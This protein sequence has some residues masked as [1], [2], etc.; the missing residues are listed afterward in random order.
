MVSQG[1]S[2][3][4]KD[5]FTGEEGMTRLLVGKVRQASSGIGL[6]TGGEG[7]AETQASWEGPLG[8]GREQSSTSTKQPA[9]GRDGSAW[10]RWALFDTGP[11]PTSMPSSYGERVSLSRRAAMAA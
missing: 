2:G 4:G 11:S 1:R 9:D 5:G 3:R 7:W 10:R 6:L 8:G